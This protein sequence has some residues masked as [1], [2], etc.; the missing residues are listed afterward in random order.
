MP[1]VKETFI[2]NDP[3][4]KDAGKDTVAQ[5]NNM[6]GNN[7]L[8]MQNGGDKFKAGDM[9]SSKSGGDFASL[10]KY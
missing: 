7:F 6:L 8:S 9:S 2:K 5:S 3:M 1:S 4:V 10:C